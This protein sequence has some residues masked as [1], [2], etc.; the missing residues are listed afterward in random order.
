[1]PDK[2]LNRIFLCHAS[3]D[4]K[5]VIG[6]Y[7]KL[8]ERG[9]NPWLD[10]IDL[11]PGQEWDKEIK[12]ALKNSQFIIIFFSNYSVSKRGYVQ[13]EFKLALDTLQTIP[14][15]QIFIIPVR[16]DD[17]VIPDSFS[18]IQYVDLFEKGGLEKVLYSIESTSEQ[19]SIPKSKEVFDTSKTHTS[20]SQPV[21]L[22]PK[23]KKNHKRRFKLIPTKKEYTDWS[24]PDKVTY[25]AFWLTIIGL[26]WGFFTFFYPTEQNTQTSL[27]VINSAIP[28]IQ[29]SQPEFTGEFMKDSTI[30]Y[31]YSFKLNFDSNKNLEEMDFIPKRENIKHLFNA[32]LACIENDQEDSKRSCIRYYVTI[33]NTRK[34]DYYFTVHAYK[35]IDSFSDCVSIK[36][37]GVTIEPKLINN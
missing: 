21:S 18:H 26:G 5:D 8:V 16:I 31:A 32:D 20:T 6:I 2:N 3:E 34:K 36:W 7:H 35:Q 29:T 10:K 23:Q 30:M 14:E 17:C 25:I 28:I 1:M 37:K 19:N 13:R 15:G 27:P 9:L 12:R 11:L 4:K 33:S 22:K 24:I